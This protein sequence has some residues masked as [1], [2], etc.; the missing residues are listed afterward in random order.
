[1]ACVWREVSCE[2]CRGSFIVKNKKVCLQKYIPY[3][4][5]TRAASRTFAFH[6]KWKSGDDFQSLLS[7]DFVEL[8]VSYLGILDINCY[9]ETS[10]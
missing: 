8:Q 1:M 4:A 10:D 2:Y 9:T 5:F 7:Q 3:I 6:P